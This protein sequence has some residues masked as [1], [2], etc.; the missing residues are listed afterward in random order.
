MSRVTDLEKEMDRLI[1][2]AE[3]VCSEHEI[4]GTSC[5][6]FNHLEQ[7]EG[8]VAS[9]KACLLHQ[10][11]ECKAQPFPHKRGASCA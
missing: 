1:S 6:L 8:A 4:E 11:C 3:E 7:L 5:N 10:P 9:A 2:A